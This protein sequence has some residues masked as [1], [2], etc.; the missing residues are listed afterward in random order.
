[1]SYIYNGRFE[2]N[3]LVVGRTECGKTGFVQR[4]VVNKFFGEIVKAEWVSYIKLDKQ[5]EAEL[6]SCFDT[7]LDFY[8]PR[9]ET[10]DQDII[11]YSDFNVNSLSYGENF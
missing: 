7:Q 4:L 6:Q 5:R 8:Y 3:I 11:S 9:S 1:M 10:S 2:G